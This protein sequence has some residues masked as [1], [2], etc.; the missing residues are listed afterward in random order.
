MAKLKF[1]NFFCRST[2]LAHKM[3]TLLFEKEKKRIKTT[4]FVITITNSKQF[5]GLFTVSTLLGVYQHSLSPKYP[6][7]SWMVPKFTALEDCLSRE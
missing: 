4:S 3:Q 2:S 7:P 5:L 6:S 1:D